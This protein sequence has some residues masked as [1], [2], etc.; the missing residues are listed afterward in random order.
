MIPPFVLVLDEAHMYMPSGETSSPAT[1]VIRELVRTARH[2]QIGVVLV[3]QSPASLDRQSFLLCNTRL[4]FALDPDDLRLVSGYLGE[5]S[6][7]V[8]NRIPRMERGTAILAS[9]MDLIR[10]PVKFRVR[11]RQSAGAIETPDLARA[12]NR[13]M[14]DQPRRDI[15]AQ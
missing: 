13:W 7:S 2:D 1:A 4:V 15:G 3:S 6:G 9:A 8:V 11:E 10:H 14:A 12:A 5:L